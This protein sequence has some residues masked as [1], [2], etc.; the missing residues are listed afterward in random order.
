MS[1]FDYQRLDDIVNL[2]LDKKEAVHIN[3]LSSYCN[4]SDRTIRSDINTINDYI[5]S[6]GARII[7]IRKKGYV[8][9]YSDK[10]SFDEF[11]S[12]QDTGTFL[13]TTSEARLTFLIRLFLTSE[14]YVSQEYL[15]SILFV[16][17]NTL[18]SDLRTLRQYLS[19]YQL[20]I[21]NK[22][23]LGYRVIGQEQDFRSA[24]VD[25]IFK[26]NFTEYL[27]ASTSVEKDIC[28]NIN[29]D[30]FNK[31]YLHLFSKEIFIDSDYFHRNIFTSLLLTVSRIKLGHTLRFYPQILLVNRNKHI[32]T[33]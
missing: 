11:W 17:Q 20:K 21:Q 25:L 22:S 31:V 6:H 29:Y 33:G 30:K 5:E 16:S 12:H 2:L 8:I 9:E 4:V 7:L 14:D 26:S 32:P 19:R 24:I 28:N 13:F 18:Y 15:Q 1:F 10:K 3:D 27:T 23:N